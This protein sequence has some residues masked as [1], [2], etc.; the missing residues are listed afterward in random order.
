MTTLLKKNIFI[1]DNRKGTEMKKE[2]VIAL[3]RS[4]K[5]YWESLS[6]STIEREFSRLGAGLLNRNSKLQKN[7]DGN[8][9]RIY[10]IEML[11]ANYTAGENL[12]PSAGQCINTCLAF[13]G[14]A[15]LIKLD[16]PSVK[17]NNVLK[18]RARRTFLFKHS[19][20]FRAMLKTQ[21]KR[22]FELDAKIG[23][24]SVFR[25]NVFS[26][27]DYTWLIK[28]LPYIQFYDYTK[29]W[30][31]EASLSN[32]TLVYSYSERTD[33]IEAMEKLHKGQNIAM[34]FQDTLPETW[35]GF[36][37]ID[38]DESDYRIADPR[39][40][41][42]GLKVKQQIGLKKDSYNSFTSASNL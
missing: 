26:D 31:R 38:G 17:L 39:G 11:P 37:V 3:R 34:V 25:L 1:R 10:G 24:K 8:A 23:I 36:P 33:P 9:V 21:V 4:I 41:V 2:T 14:H 13:S 42:V 16:V 22:R 35:N 30:S 6:I 12:C 19:P 29:V 28:E 7:P 15:R 27:V 18:K 32:Y 20:D 40:V 5:D